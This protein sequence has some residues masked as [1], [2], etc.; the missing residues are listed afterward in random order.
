MLKERCEQNNDDNN[1]KKK[2]TIFAFAFLFS[3]VMVLEYYCVLFLYNTSLFMFSFV[4]KPISF[5]H[6]L[7]DG[8]WIDWL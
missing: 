1:N 6:V 2:W 8:L 4:P 5:M 3:L 7:H